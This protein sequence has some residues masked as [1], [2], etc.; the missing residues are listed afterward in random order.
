MDAACKEKQQREPAAD[1]SAQDESDEFSLPGWS[2]QC[3]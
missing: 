2:R 1:D 3:W